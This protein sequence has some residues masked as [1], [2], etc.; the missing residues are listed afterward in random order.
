MMVSSKVDMIP[1]T[2]ASAWSFAMLEIVNTV[3]KSV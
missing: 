2:N 3:F 1:T